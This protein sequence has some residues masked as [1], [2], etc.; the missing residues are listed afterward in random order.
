MNTNTAVTNG[1]GNVLSKKYKIMI[2]EDEMDARTIFK[3]LISTNPDYEVFDAGDGN[4]AL[5]ILESNKDMDLVLLDIIIPAM[6][7]IET[8]KHIKLESDKYGKPIVIM[9][10]NIGGE[11]AVEHSK[12]FKADGYILKIDVEPDQLMQRIADILKDG[13]DQ[14]S[15][16]AQEER[17]NIKAPQ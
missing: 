5:K 6:D 10:T 9:L 3:T 8:L 15:I 12:E 14:A 11:K 7:G 1:A 13:G 4:E 17:D 2:V 16:A